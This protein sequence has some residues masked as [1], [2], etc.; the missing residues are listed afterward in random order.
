ME[1]PFRMDALGQ[2]IAVVQAR[3]TGAQVEAVPAGMTL[4]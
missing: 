1:K 3:M 4:Y 2:A